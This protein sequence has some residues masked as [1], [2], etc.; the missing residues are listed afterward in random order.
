MASNVGMIDRLA[1]LG[2]IAVGLLLTDAFGTCP[3][4]SMLGCSTR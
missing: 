4:Y 1:R 3:A 2:W